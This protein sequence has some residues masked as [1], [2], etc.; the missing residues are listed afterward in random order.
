MTKTFLVPDSGLYTELACGLGKH[1]DKVKYFTPY[2]A[3]FFPKY[4][5]FAIGKGF[6]NITK[7]KYLF[8]EMDKCDCLVNFGVGGNDLINY[9]RKHFPD[10]P[11]F[12]SGKGQKLED[13]RWGLKKV[14]EAAGIA[15]AK[16][17]KI[18]GVHALCDYLLKNPDKYVKVGIFRGSIN[19]F[20][21][22]DYKSVEQFMEYCEHELGAFSE[23]FEFVVEDSIPSSQEWGV[24]TFF[25]GKD[26]IK[27][28][29]YGVELDKG[30]YIG[31][32][33]DTLPKP[34]QETMNKLRPVLKEL[35]WRGCISTEEKIIT[36]DK[37][38]F[39]DIC[40]RSA[41]PLGLLY[42]E[43]IDNWPEM[44]FDIA[45]GKSAKLGTKVKY[46]GCVPLY[47]KHTKVSDTQINFD[48]KLRKNIKFMT[49]YCK[50]NRYY[51]VKNS[52]EEIACVVVAGDQ[53]LN[54]LIKQLKNLVD[55]VDCY[56]IDKNAVGRLD[57]IQEIITSS[58][59]LGI[60][61]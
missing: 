44:C 60:D 35:D 42:P 52:P 15:S 50:N 20:Y 19:S 54:G 5:D 29:I 25:N 14:L 24:D 39:L 11:C 12:G 58:K 4:S 17:V 33:S 21:A 1:G 37:H 57:K 40:A 34:L 32:V 45:C 2:H 18:T 56:E 28:Y 9:I 16:A 6:E 48:P 3:S 41:N 38:Y 27:P 22:K 46:V 36:A 23:D 55:Q 53:T 43:F 47:S 26:Y 31:K 13:S 51:A 49:A 7:I 61:F 30:S 8:D 59:K 10:K